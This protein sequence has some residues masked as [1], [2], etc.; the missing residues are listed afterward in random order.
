MCARFGGWA[1]KCR[2]EVNETSWYFSISL[3]ARSVAD[4]ASPYVANMPPRHLPVTVIAHTAHGLPIVN[5]FWGSEGMVFIY[6]RYDRSSI[7]LANV[8]G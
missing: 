4:H 8:G 7:R 3:Y 6:F 5:R 1:N 2:R